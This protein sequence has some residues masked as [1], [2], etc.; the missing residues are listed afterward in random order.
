MLHYALGEEELSTEDKGGSNGVAH[1]LQDVHSKDHFGALTVL[2]NVVSDVLGVL[3]YQIEGPEWK[4]LKIC[5]RRHT[6]LN[7]QNRFWTCQFFQLNSILFADAM[8]HNRSQHM[9][10]C[11]RL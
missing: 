5:A 11:E 2:D 6:G 7:D 9:I 1:Q 8:Y 3:A 4:R 10:S